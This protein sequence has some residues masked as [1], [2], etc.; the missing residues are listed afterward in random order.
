LAHF[1]KDRTIYNAIN[2]KSN[3]SKLRLRVLPILLLLFALELFHHFSR[4]CQA[5]LEKLDEL[6]QVLVSVLRHKVDSESGLAHTHNWE[7]N[8]IHVNA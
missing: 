1:K 5:F 4:L 6:V 7:L 2:R 3:I 8:A